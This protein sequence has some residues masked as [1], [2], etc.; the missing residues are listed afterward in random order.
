VLGTLLVVTSVCVAIA[1]G[2]VLA[3]GLISLT[4]LLMAVPRPRRAEGA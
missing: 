4:L 2:A 1:L 3:K